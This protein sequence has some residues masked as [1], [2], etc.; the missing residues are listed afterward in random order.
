MNRGTRDGGRR[1]DTGRGQFDSPSCPSHEPGLQ[2]VRARALSRLT[3][4]LTTVWRGLP[5]ADGILRCHRRRVVMITER[6]QQLIDEIAA[7]PP[8]EQD[9][10]AAAMQQ[11]F[12]LPPATSDT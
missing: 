12:D 2:T 8:E 9:R 4:V 10:M 3:T 1:C 5:L 11:V 7:L 6:L